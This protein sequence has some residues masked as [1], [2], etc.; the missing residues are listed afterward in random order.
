MAVIGGSQS[1]FPAGD[2]RMAGWWISF[3]FFFF[4]E[5]NKDAEGLGSDYHSAAW[6]NP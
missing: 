5:Q 2:K 4:L 3:L 1:L 6:E